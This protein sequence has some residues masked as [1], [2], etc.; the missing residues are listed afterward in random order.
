MNPPR[1]ERLL[2]PHRVT[3]PWPV[4]PRH[5]S[6]ATTG[7]QRSTVPTSAGTSVNDEKLFLQ[8]TAMLVE[9]FVSRDGWTLEQA[10]EMLRIKHQVTIDDVLLAFCQRLSARGPGRQFVPESEADQEPAPLPR[11]VPAALRDMV[12]RCLMKQPVDRYPSI[13]QLHS[14]LDDLD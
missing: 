12:S 3:P 1:S 2:F 9:R 7:G 8:S 14:A 5:D 6:R 4:L 13:S 10:L 11:Q